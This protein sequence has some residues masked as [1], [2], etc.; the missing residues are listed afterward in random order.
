MHHDD[1]SL[2]IHEIPA[3]NGRHVR[4]LLEIYELLLKHYNDLE[5]FIHFNCFLTV[6]KFK[7]ETLEEV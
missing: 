1:F 4:P 7:T 3:H 6:W 5:Y 2:K